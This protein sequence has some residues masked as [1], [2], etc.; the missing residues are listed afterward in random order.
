VKPNSRS[1]EECRA[2]LRVALAAQK[3]AIKRFREILRDLPSG[4][5]HPDGSERIVKTSRELAKV[6][7]TVVK[8]LVKLNEISR[9]G[10]RRE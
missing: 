10:K 7:N 6:Q 4:L 9:D 5:P 8:L 2:Q 3:I 1:Q